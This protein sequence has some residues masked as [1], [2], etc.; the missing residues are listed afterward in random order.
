MTDISR[1]LIYGDFLHNGTKVECHDQKQNGQR[2]LVAPR[3]L[4]LEEP[5]T[6]TNS[7]TF[8]VE[9][10]PNEL[11]KSNLDVFFAHTSPHVTLEYREEKEWRPVNVQAT[12]SAYGLRDG[13]AFRFAATRAASPPQYGNSGFTLRLECGSLSETLRVVPAPFLLASSLDPCFEVM[14]VKNPLTEKFVADLDEIVFKAGARLFPL[15]FASDAVEDVWMQDCI[16]IGT[17]S[18]PEMDADIHTDAAFLPGIRGLHDGINTKPLDA[19]AVKALEKRGIRPATALTPRPHTRWIDWYGNLEVSPPVKSKSGKNFPLGRVLYGKQNAL[20]MHPD[21]LA[22]LERQ[23]IQTPALAVDTSWLTI[24]HVDEVI[25]FVPARDRKRF[26]VLLPS[27]A[28][29]THLLEQAAQH[30]HADAP[31]FAGKKKQTTAA[32][33]LETIGRSEESRK[34]Q[35]AVDATQAQLKEELGLDDADFVTMPVLFEEGLAVIPNGVNGLVVNGHYIVPAPC[36][37]TVAGKDIFEEAIR[38]RLVK[39]GL[40]LHFLD[41]WE[42]YHSRSGEIHCGTNAIRRPKRNDWWKYWGEK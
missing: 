32:K 27:P 36:G 39:L 38:T 31:V 35:A 25:N 30:G 20:A 41:I 19:E 14:V 7:L 11:S 5:R 10:P 33:L 18:A 21:V 15:E 4:S 42:P 37:A 40:K 29:A 28:L 6:S 12:L 17:Y 16:E 22:F 2:F 3:C 34:I 24:G 9:V 26:R 8:R 23:G 1:I 13:V